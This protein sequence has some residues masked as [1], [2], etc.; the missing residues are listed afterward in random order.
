M[1]HHFSPFQLRQLVRLVLSEGAQLQPWL[2]AILAATLGEPA[3]APSSAD[4]PGSQ[5]DALVKVVI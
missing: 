2:D 5:L 3:A 4:S 1:N